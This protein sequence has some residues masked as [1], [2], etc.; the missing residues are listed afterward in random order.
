MLKQILIILPVGIML[1]V[2]GTFTYVNPKLAEFQAEQIRMEVFSSC[3]SDKVVGVG[4][5]EELIFQD[6]L[7]C[8][9]LIAKE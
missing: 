7:D 1:G 8:Y 6:V 4:S 5:Y 3:V 2:V 9:Q